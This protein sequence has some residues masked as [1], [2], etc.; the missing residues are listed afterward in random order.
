MNHDEPEFEKKLRKF[1]VAKECPRCRQLALSYK[2][3]K[4]CC[5]SCGYEE[6]IPSLR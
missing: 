4:I 5:S 1:S 2:N 3:N 6:D